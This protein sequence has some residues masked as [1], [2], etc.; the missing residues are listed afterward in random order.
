MQ[1]IPIVLAAPDMVLAREV[2]RS[3]NPTAPPVCGIGVVLT[4]SL[5]ERLKTMGIQTLTVEGHP[6]ALEGEKGLDEHLQEL[7]RRFSKVS[8]DPLMMKLLEIHRKN[9]FQAWGVD[10]G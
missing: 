9:L 7:D 8:G 5:L 10:E 3:D 6:L 2:R 4:E 1:N